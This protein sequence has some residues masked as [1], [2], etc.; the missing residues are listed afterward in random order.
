M[1]GLLLG[2]AY[3]GIASTKKLTTAGEYALISI[4]AIAGAWLLLC[5]LIQLAS[6][7]RTRN[8]PNR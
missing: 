5:L 4:L 6:W 1:T 7:L 3:D 8:D 2:L